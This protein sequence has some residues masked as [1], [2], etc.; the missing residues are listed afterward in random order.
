MIVAKNLTKL[1]STGKDQVLALDSVSFIL[2]DKG[3]VFI[4]GKSGS[5]KSTLINML[6]GLDDITDGEV[7]V[8]GMN[9]KKLK[10][11]ELDEYHNNY[12]GIIY[13]NYNLFEEETVLNNI[14]IANVISRNKKSVEEIKEL[15]HKLDLKDKLDSLVMNLSGGQKQ[16]VAIARA[17]VKDPKLILADEPTG[18]LDSKTTHSIF[19]LLKKISKERLV[20]VITHDMKSALNFADR[21]ISLSD[22]KIVKDLT[23]NVKGSSALTYIELDETQ[24][25][26]DEQINELNES[27]KKTKYHLIR[28]GHHFI[29]T[30][31]VENPENSQEFSAKKLKLNLNKNN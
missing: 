30:E 8:D 1:Y 15:L 7:I 21:I 11:G 25:I 14:Q 28:K 10:Q 29:P 19:N 31:S 3:L 18:N 20:I 27:I 9:I 16:R 4:V 6:G 26:S 13:Q 12:L 17:L 24:E 2:P 23:K 5:G 22:G